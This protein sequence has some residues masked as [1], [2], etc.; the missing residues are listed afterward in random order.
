MKTTLLKMKNIIF[1]I[2]FLTVINAVAQIPNKFSYQAVVRNASGQL[3]TNTSIGV[4]IQ[5]WQFNTDGSATEQFREKHTITTNANGLITLLIGQGTVE[6]GNISGIDWSSGLSHKIQVRIDLAGGTNYTIVSN[7]EVLAS[8]PMALSTKKSE[9][10]VWTKNGTHISNINNLGNVGVGISSPTY[11]LHVGNSDA[12]FRI[13]GPSQSSNFAKALS[14]GGFGTV[15][16]DAPGIE[17][18]RFYIQ[19]NG[20]ISIGSH[21]LTSDKLFVNGKTRTLDLQVQN[22]AGAGKV[23]TSDANGNATWQTPASPT[24]ISPTLVYGLLGAISQNIIGGSS[25][26]VFAGPTVQVTITS[27]AQKIIGVA[28]APLGL[29]AGSAAQNI[30]TGMC[31]QLVPDGQI[32]NFAGGSYS[33][34]TATSTRTTFGAST[35]ITGLAP[36]TYNIGFGVRNGGAN[37]LSNNDFVNGWVMVLP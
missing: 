32:T 4:M 28:N 10:N 7:P 35:T 36:G 6:V 18:G 37:T 14:I 29:A 27:T 3:V 26:P 11:K 30:E 1:T 13:E 19:D 25:I 17:N 22:G 12:A 16:V 23:L 31:Y 15:G 24:P 5:L 33:L 21:L 34:T 2:L 8:V 20:N 9:D